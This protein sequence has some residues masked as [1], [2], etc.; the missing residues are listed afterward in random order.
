MLRLRG[1]VLIRGE[2][3]RNQGTAY[4]AEGTGHN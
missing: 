4:R 3:R 1:V 2:M